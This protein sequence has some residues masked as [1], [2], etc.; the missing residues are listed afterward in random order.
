MQNANDSTFD[1]A[2]LT[3][4]VERQ[5]STGDA[6][7]AVVDDDD[8]AEADDAAYAD[9]LDGTNGRTARR[10]RK[11]RLL[12]ALRDVLG[13]DLSGAEITISIKL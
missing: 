4:L 1:A 11:H 9:F 8:S 3:A 2:K 13:N 7:S 6:F 5:R 10:A 12:E